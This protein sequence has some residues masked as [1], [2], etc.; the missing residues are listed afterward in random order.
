MTWMEVLNGQF[1]DGT[2]VANLSIRTLAFRYGLDTNPMLTNNPIYDAP[3]QQ[4]GDLALSGLS[5]QVTAYDAATGD[6]TLKVRYDDTQLRPSAIRWTGQL[7]TYPVANA[8]GGAEINIG[9][10]QRLTLDRGLTPQRS[11]KT[12][13]GDFVNDTRLTVSAGTKVAVGSASYVALL[14]S[15]TT[16]L[17][18]QGGSVYIGGGGKLTAYAGTTVSLQNRAD[19]SGSGELKAGAKLVVRST[20]TT[21][22]GPYSW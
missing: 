21:I 16:L 1:T 5:V 14:G 7:R 4:S 3:T 11:A 10:G 6:L 22:N 12:T 17:V 15:G 13:N 9:N 19:L 18:E 8:T 2:L 20:N